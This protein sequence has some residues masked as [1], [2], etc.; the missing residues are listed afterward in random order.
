MIGNISYGLKLTTFIVD[1]ELFKI[2]N[3]LTLRVCLQPW[4]WWIL[5]RM[6]LTNRSRLISSYSPHIRLVHFLRLITP[7][8]DVKFQYC[9]VP[10][11]NLRV[12][13]GW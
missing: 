13:N 5:C 4:E 6:K 9:H 2:K 8:V 12:E 10:T 3:F 1:E 7:I 11:I